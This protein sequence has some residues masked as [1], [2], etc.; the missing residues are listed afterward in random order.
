MKLD[1]APTLAILFA[2]ALTWLSATL[3]VANSETFSAGPPLPILAW[4]GVPAEH[5][6]PERFQELADA[7]FTLSFSGAPDPDVQQKMLDAAHS[8]GV[9]LFIWLPQ[10]ASA[11]EATARQF[12]DHP[13]LAGYYLR[14][15]PPA[16]EFA[17]LGELARRIASADGDHPS[18]VNLLPTYGNTQQWGTPD[19]QTYLDRYVAEIP[20]SLLSYDHYPIVRT[21]ADASTDTLRADFYQNLE[22]C[23]ATA[24]R[25]DR[26]LQTFALL[27]AHTPYPIPTIEHLRLQA[28]SNLAYGTQALQYFTY[29]TPVSDTWNF[30]EAPI[31][32]DGERTPTYD[33]VK[34]FNAELQAL[35]GVFVG[36]KV[37]SLGHTGDAIPAG[38][39]RY[40]PI[41]PVKSLTTQGTGLVVSHLANGDNRFLVLVNRDIHA[42]T[43][44]RVEFDGARFVRQVAKDGTVGALVQSLTDL[45]ISPG[46]VAIFTWKSE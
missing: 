29:W 24:R 31:N 7:G 46:D 11:P 30:H 32:V 28:Y 33:L 16:T 36:S 17:A 14:D 18:Y 43:A 23:A 44:A 42:P 34:E 22:I 12:K 6:T 40:E 20:S 21:G 35:R 9:G 10:L 2:T 39:T 38:T 1:I 45:S 13:A 26:Q 41:A 19:Y 8:A 3:P 27:V 37:E 5:A 4:N 25:A 15:E